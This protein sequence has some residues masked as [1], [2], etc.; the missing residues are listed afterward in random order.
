VKG[1]KR[2]QLKKAIEILKKKKNKK[3]VGDILKEKEEKDGN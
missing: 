2:R 3:T 1:Y